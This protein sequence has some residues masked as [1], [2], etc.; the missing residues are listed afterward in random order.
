[1]DEDAWTDGGVRRAVGVSDSAPIETGRAG[2][3]VIGVGAYVPNVPVTNEFLASTT[4]LTAEQIVE[5]TGV[6][7]RYRVA[8][9]EAASTISAAAARAALEMAGV[10]PERVGLVVGCTYTGDYVFPGDGL[11]RRRAHRGSSRRSLRPSR[12]LHRVPGRA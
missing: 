1:M 7:M 6:E 4:G 3:S 9:G 11:S 12:Q 2:V 10:D 8:E 5:R